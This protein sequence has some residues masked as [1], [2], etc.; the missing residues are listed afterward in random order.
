MSA[1]TTKP[2]LPVI[3]ITKNDASSYNYNYFT[4]TFDFRVQKLQASP[5][6]DSK[7]GRFVLGLVSSDASNANANTFLS[8]IKNGNEITI[9]LGKS[10]S[11]LTNIMRGV[12]EDIE[13]KEPTNNLMQI[14]LSGPDWGSDIL[15]NR[16]S[17]YFKI[18]RYKADNI[19]LDPTDPNVTIKQLVSDLLTSTQAYPFND[20]TASAQG[21]VYSASNIDGS[22]SGFTI[23]QVMASYEHLDD[24]L[25]GLDQFA[26]AVHYVDY[27]KNF[28]M[29]PAVPNPDPKSA[30]LFTDNIN[31]SLISSWPS[32]KVGY[33]A[34]DTNYKYTVEN[35]KHRIIGIGSDQVSIDGSQT[36]T[37]VQQTVNSSSDNLTSSTWLAMKYTPQAVQGYQ[38]QI[39]V[40]AIGIPTV[41][42]NVEIIQDSGGKPVG[43]VLRTLSIPKGQMAVGGS[44]QALNIGLD[45]QSTPYWIVLPSNPAYGGNTFNWY[46]GG[47]TSTISTSPDGVTWTNQNNVAGYMFIN[48][49]NLPLKIPV[50]GT[51]LSASDKVFHEETY[52]QPFITNYVAFGQY[53]TALTRVTNNKKEIFT[54][55]IYSPDTIPLPFNTVLLRK[56]LSGLTFNTS[57]VNTSWSYHIIGEI[58][59]NFQATDDMATGLFWIDTQLT[60]FTSF[61]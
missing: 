2:V 51:A 48:F 29:V 24:K 35:Y 50:P 56:K 16:I 47:T 3:A 41:D 53:L 59:Y 21:V 61:P 20:I 38:V 30:W 7:G 31:D 43:Q 33:I 60:R 36:N 13:I 4:N 22:I 42:L 45:Y 52:R 8:N 25:I 11:T 46:K 28:I 18:Q 40:G 1:P 55:R 39:F 27:N 26:Q 34:P 12:I 49:T 54:C 15:K 37:P 17:L 5:P 23:P 9:K 44:W 58:T 57:D 32:G 6:V 14:T 10:N 19:T